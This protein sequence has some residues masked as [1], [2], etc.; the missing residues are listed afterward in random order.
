MATLPSG[1]NADPWQ[2]AQRGLDQQQ[3]RFQQQE[4]RNEQLVDQILEPQNTQRRMLAQGQAS[5]QNAQMLEGQG[6]NVSSGRP[7]TRQHQ[8]RF[9]SNQPGN[10]EF[11]D[12]F[13]STVQGN[14]LTNPYALAAVAA[15]GQHESGWS[16]VHDE[17]DDPSESGQQGRSGLALSWRDARLNAARQFA[18]KMGDDPNAPSAQ[19]QAMFFLN[20][21][22][23][24][25]N[26]LNNAGSL[27]EAV[28]VMRDAW[29]YADPNN[30]QTRARLETAN[31]YLGLFGGRRRTAGQLDNVIDAQEDSPDTPEFVTRMEPDKEKGEVEKKYQRTWLRPVD[32][33]RMMR[34][35]TGTGAM[36]KVEGRI[37]GSGTKTEVSVLIPADVV[38][39][40]GVMQG[41]TPEE[42]E[43][44]DEDFVRGLAGD[45]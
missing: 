27:D 42:D 14:G 1:I 24:L 4:Q 30:S 35:M 19:T 5:L 43:E 28:T 26:R 8:Q 18:Q 3:R 9:K 40:D 22:P 32:A 44:D 45:F 36:P 23:E 16:R 33:D 25:V 2:L 34:M 39:E 29:R 6:F 11:F 7:S 10:P 17:W 41:A 21:D 13:M 12:Q 20:E 15:T 38:M 31:H 37:R